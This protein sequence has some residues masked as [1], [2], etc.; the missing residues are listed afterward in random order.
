MAGAGYNLFTTGSVL[1]AAQVNTFLQEQTV[2][3]FAN[4]AART[5]ALS[6]VLAEGMMSY[7]DDTN[8]VEVYNGSAWV[9]VSSDQTP[10]TTKGDLFTYTTTDARLGVGSNGQ[11]LSADSTTSTGLKWVTPTTVTAPV[12]TIA[13][14][15]NNFSTSSTTFVDLTDFTV[16]R[17]P[18]SGTNK[19]KVMLSFTCAISQAMGISIKVLAGATSLNENAYYENYDGANPKTLTMVTYI[20]N[21]AASSTVFKAQIKVNAGTITVYGQN[22]GYAANFSVLEVY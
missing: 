19:I 21:N 2:M 10:L 8:S 22:S 17:T 14:P 12:L 1:T 18:V 7:L 6:G 5:T 13:Q 16:T 20:S 4:A 3:R 9:S 11:Y 15:A